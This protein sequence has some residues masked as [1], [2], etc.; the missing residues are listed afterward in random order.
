[1]NIR[2]L[3]LVFLTSILFGGAGLVAWWSTHLPALHNL[4]WKALPPGIPELPNLTQAITNDDS[5]M[6]DRPL[7]WESRRPLTQ[8]S[9][10]SATPQNSSP[11]ELVGIVSEGAQHIAL[12]RTLPSTPQQP[13]RRLRPSE[14]INGMT[15]Q[16]IGMDRV[17]LYG[18]NGIQ[19]LTLKRGGQNA[20]QTPAKAAPEITTEMP[21][22]PPPPNL[23]NRFNQTNSAFIRP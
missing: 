16:S 13:V 11:I 19:V 8:T 10:P 4:H 18:S 23:L 20:A 14:T 7:F 6:I 12:L 3:Q 21:A 22:Q 2:P 5:Q 17:T 9:T 1:M 15:I